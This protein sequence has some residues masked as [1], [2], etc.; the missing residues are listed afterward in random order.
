MRK[1]EKI[2]LG[3]LIVLSVLIVVIA[4]DFWLQWLPFEHSEQYPQKI[5]ALFVAVS[6]LVT[7][8]VVYATFNATKHSNL[9]EQ[10]RRN[11]EIDK[12]NRDRKEQLLKEII[13]W[14]IDVTRTNFG[15]EIVVTPGI[16]EEKQK[17][18]D[19]VNLLLECQ[20]LAI[21]G[22]ELLIPGALSIDKDLEDTVTKVVDSLDVIQ[23]IL[24]R[25][26]PFIES[27]EVKAALK[28]N[29][30]VLE[31]NIRDL[32]N[33]IAIYRTNYFTQPLLK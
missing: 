21:R 18:R 16:S 17:R 27:Q 24:K 13:D 10:E 28:A 11:D 12:E 2:I 19:D 3:L 9:R 26:A 20:V 23:D 22:K 6:A 31:Q 5:A 4:T 8:L 15:G 32:L 1:I 7:L 33:S 25:G 14:A 30:P 29:D